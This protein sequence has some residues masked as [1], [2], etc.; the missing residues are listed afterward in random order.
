M[1]MDDNE[2]LSDGWEQ[3]GDGR[4]VRRDTDGRIID[5]RLD[6]ETARAMQAGRG[7]NRNKQHQEDINQ[8]LVEA[9]YTNP[10]DA[11][12]HLRQL[13]SMAA[14]GRSGSVSALVAFI[15]H[16]RAGDVVEADVP[17][18]GSICPKCRQYVGELD[19]ETLLKLLAMLESY[20]PGK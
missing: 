14:S 11:P 17:E 16:T 1:S 3:T 10:D 15:R 20:E 5:S 6:P 2:L 12:A 9:G 19:G 18:L 4:Q 13:A 8:L 7:K